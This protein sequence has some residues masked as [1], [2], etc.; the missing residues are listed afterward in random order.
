MNVRRFEFESAP[1]PQDSTT[2][3]EAE[4]NARVAMRAAPDARDDERQD[5]EPDEPGYGHGV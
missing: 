4:L 2:R 1:P 3:P 5:E